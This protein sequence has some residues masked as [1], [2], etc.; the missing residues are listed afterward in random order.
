[1][2]SQILYL[3]ACA[4]GDVANVDECCRMGEMDALQTS[5]QHPLPDNPSTQEVNQSCTEAGANF[6]WWSDPI[7]PGHV[8]RSAG[9]IMAI[10]LLLRDHDAHVRQ[11]RTP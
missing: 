2:Q 9:F 1:M 6:S 3:Y 5:S 11:L 10:C 4:K 7:G 8:A